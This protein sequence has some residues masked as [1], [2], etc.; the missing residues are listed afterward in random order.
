M[1]N[2][3]DE[4]QHILDRLKKLYADG[5]L[6]RLSTVSLSTIDVI[7]D[8]SHYSIYVGHDEETDEIVDVP[9]F[10]LVDDHD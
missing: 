7:G 9:S 5:T 3:L 6:P 4:I 8:Q 1:T 2:P 10:E